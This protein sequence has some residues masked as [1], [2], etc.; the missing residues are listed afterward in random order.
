MPSGASGGLRGTQPV[1][2]W[3]RYSSRIGAYG[4]C[5]MG[6]TWQTPVQQYLR[7]ALGEA[8]EAGTGGYPRW[9]T[10]DMTV[11]RDAARI[12]AEV[13]GVQSK[14]TTT[15]TVN[16]MASK[17]SNRPCACGC[18]AV[19]K[20][21]SWAP[22]HDARYMA[23]VHARVKEVFG[24]DVNVTLLVGELALGACDAVKRASNN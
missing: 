9:R 10:D 11:V 14:E 15:P 1:T 3:I 24:G 5:P 12:M 21:G 2:F 17:E 16:T 20:S 23:S 13:Q 6:E 8:P 22:G 18:G 7:R 19:S 4:L